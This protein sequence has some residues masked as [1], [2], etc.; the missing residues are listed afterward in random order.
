MI[1]GAGNDTLSGSV[2]ADTFKWSLGDQGSAGTPA[3]D[4]ITGF[5]KSQGDMLDISDLLQGENASNLTDYLHFTYD[6][7]SKA[8]T[9]HISSGGGYS[10]GYTSS[11]TDQQIVLNGIN[12]VNSSSDSDIITQLKAAGYLITN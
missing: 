6:S 11:S 3:V 2:G 8:T 10:G 5:S 1:G 7:T 12:L 9:L 4:T